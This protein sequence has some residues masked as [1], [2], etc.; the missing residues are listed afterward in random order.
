[1]LPCDFEVWRAVRPPDLGAPIPDNC[2]IVSAEGRGV[3]DMAS[4]DY[5]GDLLMLNFGPELA[6][7]AK[8]I[9]KALSK[10]DLGEMQK[11]LDAEMGA[12]TGADLVGESPRQLAECYLKFGANFRTEN[13]R[14]NVT[15]RAERGFRI[16]LKAEQTK[17]R[18]RNM[19]GDCATDPL[20]SLAFTLGLCIHA[21]TDVPKHKDAARVW[22]TVNRLSLELGVTQ[23]EKRSSTWIGQ[24]M[25][26]LFQTP[27]RKMAIIELA[28]ETLD[29]AVGLQTYGKYWLPDQT[30]VLG[31]EAGRLVAMFILGAPLGERYYD[32]VVVRTVLG[33]LSCLI[34]Q[35]FQGQFEKLVRG[36]DRAIFELIIENAGG[37]FMRKRSVDTLSFLERSLHA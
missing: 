12:K 36:D 25:L 24:K 32:R 37:V 7:L 26:R 23:K 20:M 11:N 9:A 3:Q 2:I 22:A 16:V 27:L 6:E 8:L 21:S 29:L 28:T 14:G 31:R 18:R 34:R 17:R 10:W 19:G 5:D 4:G 30:Y 35:R 13:I 1:M 33:E 15:A